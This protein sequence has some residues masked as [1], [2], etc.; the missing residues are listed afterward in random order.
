MMMNKILVVLA[1]VWGFV[2]A[3]FS[4]KTFDN[5]TAQSS[6]WLSAGAYCETNTYMSRPYKGPATG[7]VPTFVLDDKDTDTQV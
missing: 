1:C 3:E 4:G 5:S 7:F 6:V 2:A